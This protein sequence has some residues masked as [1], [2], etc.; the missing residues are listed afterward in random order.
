MSDQLFPVEYVCSGCGKVKGEDQFYFVNDRGIRRRLSHCKPCHIARVNG[1]ET[2][3]SY[4][5][6]WFRRY[7]K[8]PYGKKAE[9]CRAKLNRAVREGRIDRG[10]CEICGTTSR[11]EA[12]HHD[13]SK[14]FDVLWLCKKHH[15]QLHSGQLEASYVL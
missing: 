4:C 15:E 5:R 8:T 6:D 3:K 12:H 2:R 10:P 1:R 11:V 9:A 13:Y 14:P 7:R